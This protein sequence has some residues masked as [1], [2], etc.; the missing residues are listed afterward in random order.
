MQAL[1]LSEK[2]YLSAPRLLCHVLHLNVTSWR[3]ARSAAHPA[4]PDV[5]SCAF[6]QNLTQIY[7]RY[8]ECYQHGQP[9]QSRCTCVDCGNDG[10]HAFS[11]EV[12]QPAH[13]KQPANASLESQRRKRGGGREE[14]RLRGKEGGRGREGWRDEEKEGRE[15]TLQ[16]SFSIHRTLRHSVLGYAY[17]PW[18]QS[19]SSASPTPAAT[20]SAGAVSSLGGAAVHSSCCRAF[21]CKHLHTQAHTRARAQIYICTP[22]AQAVCHADGRVED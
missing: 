4:H 6:D 14:E 13:A 16:T 10:Q 3:H 1:A 15:R 2:V 17:L 5:S 21:A 18:M 19:P 12:R 9:C 11:I 8:C 7:R 22:G 20:A